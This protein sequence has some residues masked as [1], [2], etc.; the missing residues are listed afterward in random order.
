MS[1]RV[2]AYGETYTRINRYKSKKNSPKM[3]ER[4]G[5]EKETCVH[6]FITTNIQRGVE[7]F[8]LNDCN[9]ITLP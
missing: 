7:R 2:Y 4:H 8:K 9:I 1:E 6:F 3:R 5:E